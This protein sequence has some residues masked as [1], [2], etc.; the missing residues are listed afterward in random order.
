LNSGWVELPK[1]R[2]ARQRTHIA[3]ETRPAPSDIDVHPTA[4]IVETSAP[5][6]V[7]SPR[8]QRR[9]APCA[10][11]NPGGTFDAADDPI[12]AAVPEP[13]TFGLIGAG[14]SVICC[15][16]RRKRSGHC[17]TSHGDLLT[18]LSGRNRSA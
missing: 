5:G 2:S 1:D 10:V 11:A 12:S 7:P 14:L 4:A 9:N 8:R 3:K 6:I 16:A 13:A 18:S 17:A 15:A